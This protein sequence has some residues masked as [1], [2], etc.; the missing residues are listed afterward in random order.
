M[1]LKMQPLPALLRNIK[2][3]EVQRTGIV[4]SAEIEAFVYST[5][6]CAEE[7]LAIFINPSSFVLSYFYCIWCK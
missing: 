2:I 1:M 3:A 5:L 7:F 4:K 6:L